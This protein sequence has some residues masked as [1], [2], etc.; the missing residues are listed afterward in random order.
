MEKQKNIVAAAL[1]AVGFLALG[2][3]IKAGI[4]NMANKGRQVTVRGAAEREV[5]ANRVKWPISFC[6]TG[7]DLQAVNSNMKSQNQTI[8]DFLKANGLEDSDIIVNPPAVKDRYANRWGNDRPMDRYEISSSI[9][10][11]SD[12]VEAVRNASFKTGELIQKGIILNAAQEYDRS[13]QISYEY[14]DFQ[15][16][17]LEM[18][19]ESIANAQAAAVEFASNAG[20]KIGA[21]ITASQGSLSIGNSDSTTPHIQK[22]RVV[23]TMTYALE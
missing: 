15:E 13:T 12:K 7:N 2:L 11:K 4:D 5:L 1:I 6:I 22:L 17:K 10:V 14:T 8:I 9:T 20:S 21:L 19:R 3:C 18:T 23:S 16:V